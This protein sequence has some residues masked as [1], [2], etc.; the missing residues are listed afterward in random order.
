M[1]LIK[2]DC[3]HAWSGFLRSCLPVRAAPSIAEEIARF[4]FVR[5]AR[6]MPSLRPFRPSILRS[7]TGFEVVLPDAGPLDSSTRAVIFDGGIPT[8]AR[9][10]LEPWVTLV[11]PPGIGSPVPAFEEHGLGV[12]T[13]FL[14][15]YL[16]EGQVPPVP[17]CRV[18]HVR[19]LDNKAGS[20]ND[21]DYFDVLDRSVGHLDRNPALY[22]LVN[23]SLG[24]SLAVDDDEVTLWTAALDKRLAHGRSVATVAAGNDGERDAETGLNRVQ[25]PADGVNV[26]SVGA[27]DRV[28]EDWERASYS[29]V[30]PGRCPGVVKPDG[31]AFGGSILEPFGVLTGALKGGHEAGTSFAAPFALRSGA[32]VMA[33]LG[34]Q[35]S[36]LAVRALL[37]HRAQSTDAHTLKHVGW[38]RFEP[39]S[40]RLITCD[41]DEALVVFQGELPVGEHLRAP[42]PI[43]GVTLKGKVT[44]S[45][46]LVI[47]PEVDPEHPGTYAFVVALKA[48]KVPELYDQVLR[49]YANVLVPIQPRTRI[50]VRQ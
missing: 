13:A 7:D 4:S 3:A 25:P 42:I 10:L 37:I 31:V 48:A 5:V 35:L 34:S 29:C 6:G 26:L 15:G 17:P 19:V 24:P 22:S 1:L 23:I 9:E 40:L 11:E 30:G 41:D 33:Q 27:A 47:A 36:P 50:Q 21:P 44:L 39:N 43:G 45:A 32:T 8:T 46:T 18:D 12:T 28:G 14:F 16:E 20:A 2:P 49:A 38:G